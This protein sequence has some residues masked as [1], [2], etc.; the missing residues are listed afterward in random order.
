L[1]KKTPPILSLNLIPLG[2]LSSPSKGANPDA[3]P[4]TL[5]EK[6]GVSQMPSR[7]NHVILMG[8]PGGQSGW[9]GK[10]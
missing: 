2:D 9:K 8:H 7:Q 10:S 6:V 4:D 5:G 1:R 3:H